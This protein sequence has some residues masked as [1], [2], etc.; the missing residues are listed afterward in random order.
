MKK[1]KLKQL[2]ALR[3]AR[4]A[5]TQ[6]EKLLAKLKGQA[7]C[8]AEHFGE[9]VTPN[10]AD[11]AELSF[12]AEWSFR[13][14]VR[15]ALAALANGRVGYRQA[16]A[17]MLQA[18]RADYEALVAEGTFPAQGQELIPEQGLRTRLMARIN[19]MPGKDAEG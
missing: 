1:S 19:Q 17:A 8:W 13:A 16:Y 15:T 11:D 3:S 5:A 2:D 10:S 7:A 9:A 12:A 18:A 6:S 14:V 4:V